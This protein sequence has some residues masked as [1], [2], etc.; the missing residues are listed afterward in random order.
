M[1][2]AGLKEKRKFPRLNTRAFIL[3][4]FMEKK[5]LNMIKGFTNN[6]STGGLMFETDRQILTQG[7]FI[8]EIYQP[9]GQS[10][11]EIISISTTAKIKWVNQIDIPDKY[12]G[13]NKHRIGI[14]FVEMNNDERKTIT[15][16]VQ[17]K[18]NL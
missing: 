17:D 15:E 12:K 16:Y 3:Y 9:L 8:L 10:G 1:N 5:R 13:S 14:E 11:E 2:I 6:I 7:I 18:L 4:R